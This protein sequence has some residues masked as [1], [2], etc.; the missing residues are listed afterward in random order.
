MTKQARKAPQT[1]TEK[2][3]KTKNMSI[4]GD[5]FV[6]WLTGGGISGFLTTILTPVSIMDIVM[7]TTDSRSAVAEMGPMARS[8]SYFNRENN[9]I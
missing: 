9:V 2:G 6:L 5:L 4:S 3:L 8:A 1:P 7:E